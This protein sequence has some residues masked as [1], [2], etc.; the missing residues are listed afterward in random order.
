MARDVDSSMSCRIGLLACIENTTA[1]LHA[2]AMT[3]P[4]HTPTRLPVAV[5]AWVFAT[6][7]ATAAEPLPEA[8]TGLQAHPQ[9]GRAPGAYELRSND[10]LQALAKACQRA[11]RGDTTLDAQLEMAASLNAASKPEAARRLLETLDTAAAQAPNGLFKLNVLRAEI[12]REGAQNASALTLLDAAIALLNTEAAPPAEWQARAWIARA[13]A[14]RALNKAGALD[15]ATQALDRAQALLHGAGVRDSYVA[16]DVL[17]QRVMVAYARDDLRETTRLA[18]QERDMIRRISGPDA[19]AQLDALTTLASVASTQR[20]HAETMQYLMEGRRIAKLA[21]AASQGGHVGILNTLTPVLIDLGQPLLALEV[22]REAVALTVA[23][24]GEGH[25]KLLTPLE[26]RAG[27]EEMLGRQAQARSSYQQLAAIAQREAAQVP[28]TQ[29][30][31]VLDSAAGFYLRVNDFDTAQRLLEQIQALAPEGG[32]LSYWRGRALRRAALLAGAQGQ[33]EAADNLHRQARPLL[34]AA[35]GQRHPYLT[36]ADALR[37]ESQVRLRRETPACAELAAGLDGLRDSTP[38]ERVVTRRALARH[39]AFLQQ[40]D[41]AAEHLSHA[42]AAAQSLAS[43]GWMWPALDDMAQQMRASGRKLQAVALAKQAVAQIETVRRQFAAPS[44]LKASYLADKLGVYRRLADWLAEDGRVDEALE[45]LRL[46]KEEEFRDFTTSRSDTLVTAT[47]MLSQTAQETRWLAGAPH[48]EAQSAAPSAAAMSP[49]QVQD[50]AAIQAREQVRQRQWVAALGAPWPV[51]ARSAR[52]PQAVAPLSAMPAPGVLHAVVFLGERHANFVVHS[53]SLQNTQQRQ[54]IRVPLDMPA[55]TRDLGQLLSRLSRREDAQALLQ[56]LHERVGAPL[57]QAARQAGA[58]QLR[59]QLDGDLRYLPFAALHDGRGYLVERYAVEQQVAG[60]TA[61][62]STASSQSAGSPSATKTQQPSWVSAF[63]TTRATAELPALREVASEICGILSG[64]VDARSS[65]LDCAT[66]RRGTLPGQAWVNESFT[67]SNLR[68]AAA[69]GQAARLDLLH[70]G[71]HFVLRPGEMG[72][73]WLQLG[74]GQRLYLQD[75]LRWR[76]QSQ[77]LVTLSACETGIG[78]GS[79]G[80]AEIEGLSSMLLRLGAGGVIAS[81]WP[82]E[83]RST[84][85]LMREL[86]REIGEGTAP[87]V[88]LRRAQL[89]ALNATRGARTSPFHWAGFYLSVNAR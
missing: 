28:A 36:A 62:A 15:A 26:R 37:C 46:L 38:A 41:L 57:E 59:L 1:Q 51:S 9:R 75:L 7:L 45:T 74:D 52:Q 23:T 70:I 35:L 44:D 39:A 43:P 27:A 12:A 47:P 72:R 58:K 14:L 83:D 24:W 50:M 66:A 60:A 87:A 73:S 6:S 68:Q 13:G 82:V 78:S 42:L 53:V 61:S 77:E 55:F 17:N 4:A 85:E 89:Q 8:C 64:P 25:A 84:S 10:P 86:Y 48:A 81:L 21:P 40:A 3:Q 29:R 34:A 79:S 54:L 76:M 11:Q 80:G 63:G 88:A 71:T 33:W 2:S 22:A 19:P 69:S 5:L 49:A 32:A 67:A 18:L 30:L 65:G 56:S 20:R 16:A 31:R